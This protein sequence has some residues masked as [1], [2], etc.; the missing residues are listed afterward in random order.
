[1]IVTEAQPSILRVLEHAQLISQLGPGN[2]FA[3]FDGVVKELRRSQPLVFSI[4][5]EDST[6]DPIT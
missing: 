6:Q 4:H 2:L 5:P 3:S 1:M